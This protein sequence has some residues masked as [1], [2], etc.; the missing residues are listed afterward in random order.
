MLVPCSCRSLRGPRRWLAS[1][2]LRR[3]ERF[4]DSWY[5]DDK[6]ALFWPIEGRVL[7]IGP[8]TGVNFDY[9]PP[10]TRVYAV[11]PNPHFHAGLE[12]RARQMGLR[13]RLV[14]GE[15]ERIP[16]PSAKF[17]H[18]VGTLVLCSVSNPQAVM[19]EVLRVLRPGG[20][21]H[22]IEHV[23]AGRGWMKPAQWLAAWPWQLVFDGCRLNRDSATTV[24]QAG[25]AWQVTA[26]CRFG[27]AW[28]P[29]QPHIIGRAVKPAGLA[30]GRRPLKPDGLP[31]GDA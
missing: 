24:A 4:G 8:G 29:V 21:Y 27:P 23:G 5:R 17:D 13:L 9:Y 10:G 16:L 1:R 31:S 14:V 12:R 28:L 2:M 22:F 18:V 11:E 3:F 26:A 15:A 30:S 25:F 6:S 19:A 20:W 7:E